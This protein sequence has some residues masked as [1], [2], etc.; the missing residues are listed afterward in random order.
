MKKSLY[1]KKIV[2]HLHR[3]MFLKFF[4][5]KVLVKWVMS[6]CEVAHNFF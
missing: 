1:F 4:I 3:K 6:D 5:V 2:L